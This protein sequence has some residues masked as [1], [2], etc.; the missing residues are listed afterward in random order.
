MYGN[1]SIDILICYTCWSNKPA[2]NEP[3]VEY[4]PLLCIE[5]D[6]KSHETEEQQ[7]RDEI[8][9]LILKTIGL[10]LIRYKLRNGI[11]NKLG[12]SN[13][14]KKIT[15]QIDDYLSTLEERPNKVCYFF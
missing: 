6:G 7:Y 15:R 8:K 13:D 2:P 4:Q 3:W 14:Y 12:G 11:I 10:K 9:D 5:I 1:K